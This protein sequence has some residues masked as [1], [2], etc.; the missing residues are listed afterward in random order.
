MLSPVCAWAILNLVHICRLSIPLHHPASKPS[1]RV[2]EFLDES[3]SGA[4][5]PL[6]GKTRR[7]A[8]GAGADGDASHEDN[9][10]LQHL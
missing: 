1:K 5:R 9:A 3:G 10:K 6:S 2:T 4:S 7:C 8:E